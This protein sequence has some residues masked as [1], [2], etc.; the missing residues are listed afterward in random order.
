M[1]VVFK[2]CIR[3]S[4]SLQANSGGSSAFDSL[5][6]CSTCLMSIIPSP[7][8]ES[9]RLGFHSIVFSAEVAK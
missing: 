8:R 3:K 1:E 6:Q 7:K 9:E 4:Y 2:V 5:I